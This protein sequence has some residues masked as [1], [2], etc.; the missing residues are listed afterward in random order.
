MSSGDVTVGRRATS[1]DD[2]MQT[3]ATWFKMGDGTYIVHVPAF[4]YAASVAKHEVVEHDDGSITCSPSLE[5]TYDWYGEGS[6]LYRWHGML[7]RGTF[8]EVE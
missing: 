7:I 8:T 3:E 6:H 1:W 2:C 5:I 4:P